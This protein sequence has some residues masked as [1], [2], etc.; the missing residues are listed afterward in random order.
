M[1]REQVLAEMA[2]MEAMDLKTTPTSD[3]IAEVAKWAIQRD[4]FVALMQVNPAAR[5]FVKSM[6]DFMVRVKA[7]LDRRVP[8]TPSIYQ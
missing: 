3:L 7:E 5:D 6:S 1:N 2:R 4:A 8:A